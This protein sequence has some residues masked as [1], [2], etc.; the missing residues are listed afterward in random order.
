[1]HS[2]LP[3]GKPNLKLTFGD[4]KEVTGLKTEGDKKSIVEE[5]VP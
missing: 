3:S 4:Q 5:R 2:I 1:M